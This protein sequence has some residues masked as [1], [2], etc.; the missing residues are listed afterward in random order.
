MASKPSM[1]DSSGT[2]LLEPGQCD[3]QSLTFGE[4][5]DQSLDNVT[6]RAGL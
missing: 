6:W 1:L 3:I 5:F 4:D 2:F